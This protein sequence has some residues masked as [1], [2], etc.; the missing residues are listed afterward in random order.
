MSFCRACEENEGGK[1]MMHG[2]YGGWMERAD[3]PGHY[4][5]YN[6]DAEPRWQVVFKE[7]SGRE[8]FPSNFRFI[9]LPAPAPPSLPQ[10]TFVD[11]KPGEWFRWA[12][13]GD[14]SPIRK[15]NDNTVLIV[16]NF[17]PTWF[18]EHLVV[19]GN[20]HTPPTPVIRIKATF[21]VQNE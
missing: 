8:I 9:K 21:E 2:V 15:I 7:L 5:I 19:N 13:P 14:W 11:L 3:G 20:W 12:R 16:N 18:E 17:P 6:P 10:L 4:W 1:C